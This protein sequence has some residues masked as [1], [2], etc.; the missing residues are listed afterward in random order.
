MAAVAVAIGIGALAL[1][2][3]GGLGA[4]ANK[5]REAEQKEHEELKQQNEDLKNQ[6]A[7]IQASENR[8]DGALNQL[9]GNEG[10]QNQ[11]INQMNGNQNSLQLMMMMDMLQ[12]MMNSG[13][14][15][16]NVFM[17]Q[18][19]LSVAGYNVPQYMFNA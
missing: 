3:I 10:W 7:Q 9:L 6:L 18:N 4:Q 8:Q 2:G 15:V 13:P 12:Q 17:Q 11:Q 14:D 19:N 1:L 16:T 5:N